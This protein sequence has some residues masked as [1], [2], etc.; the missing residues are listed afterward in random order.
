VSDASNVHYTMSMDFTNE[1]LDRFWS[2]VEVTG[3][4]WNWV[5]GKYVAGY[6][7][8]TANGAGFR[9]HRVSYVALVGPIPEGLVIDHLC[10]NVACVNP[11]HLEPVTVRV[12]TLR[13]RSPQIAAELFTKE[14]CKWGHAMPEFIPGRRRRACGPCHAQRQAKY[15][16]KKMQDPEFRAKKVEAQREYRKRKRNG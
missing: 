9:A 12:N 2:K 6:G 3:F 8:F 11:D 7:R 1:Q 4:C 15:R 13:G 10:R 16:K 5:G 14:F